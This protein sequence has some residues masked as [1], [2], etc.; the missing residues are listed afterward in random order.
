VTRVIG[1][2]ESPIRRSRG[3]APHAIGLPLAC[4]V[5]ILAV[6]G[7]LKA[8]FALGDGCRAILSHH[9]GDLDYFEAYRAFEK[10]V[11]LYEQL[12]SL[13]PKCIAHDLHP[14]YASTGYARQRESSDGIRLVA[15]QHHHAHLASCM[16]EHGLPGPVIGVTFDGTGYGTDGAV[17]GGEFLVGDYRRFRR[18]AHLRYVGMPGGERA[19]REP[20]R[21]A[22]A[23]LCD[24]EV[25]CNPL[26]A[27]LPANAART[28]ERMLDRKFNSP[29]TSS[30]GRLFDA[31]ASL[32][33]VRDS[34]SFEGQAAM[35]LEWLASESPDRGNYPYEV[36]AGSTGGAD[37]EA[38]P[39]V[40]DTRPMIRG[41]ARDV[42]RNTA[43]PLIARR[44][45]NT[46]AAIIADVCG[47]IREQTGIESV[48]LSGGVFMNAI[49]ATEAES[50]LRESGFA[51]YR[52][53]RVPPNDGGLSLGQVA[54]AAAYLLF[55][56]Q[57]FAA[58]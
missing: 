27:R 56:A 7:Q 15:V 19:V 44:F 38:I 37:G 46:M 4:P 54:I 25:E 20:W 12:F 35:Q 48:V 30:A 28:I 3:Y 9:L 53:R 24:A 45:H 21:M 31:V 32:S 16:A 33:G 14:D 34:A 26:T 57:P 29:F 11:A 18:A 8:T 39:M 36:S 23:Q 40:I 42:G 55:D 6:G 47:R 17:W 50:S 58:E 2:I 51:A 13:H 52:H 41:I 10:D 22:V 49:L 1:G 43:R 5:P